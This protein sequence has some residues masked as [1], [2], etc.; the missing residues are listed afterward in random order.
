MEERDEKL[1]N[2]LI[3][4]A[5]NTVIECLVVLISPMKLHKDLR[6]RQKAF[7]CSMGAFCFSDKCNIVNLAATGASTRLLPVNVHNDVS[8]RS[9]TQG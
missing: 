4:S 5:L 3:E 9:S 2:F 8:D 6:I 7:I 1:V